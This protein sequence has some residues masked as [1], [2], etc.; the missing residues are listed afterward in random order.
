MFLWPPCSTPYLTVL[1]CSE[2]RDKQTKPLVDVAVSS[3][4]RMFSALNSSEFKGKRGQKSE[5]SESTEQSLHLKL[6]Y[7]IM[8][9][10][11][12]EKRG[13]FWYWFKIY[14]YSC[15][16]MVKDYVL[17]EFCTNPRRQFPDFPIDMNKIMNLYRYAS[18]C[19]I[20]QTIYRIWWSSAMAI[21]IKIHDNVIK[22]VA[23][24]NSTNSFKH[25]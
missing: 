4:T 20:V 23:W 9:N 11:S 2:R 8:K 16:I 13:K 22:K 24:C 5:T 7:L 14:L 3:S 15:V 12:I 10:N 6:M 18:V 21:Y 19:L 17:V 25:Q 1:W